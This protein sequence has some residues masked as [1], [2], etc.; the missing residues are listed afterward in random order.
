MN[1]AGPVFN[2]SRSPTRDREKRRYCPRRDL[3]C[4]IVAGLL[5]IALEIPEEF[6]RKDVEAVARSLIGKVKAGCGVERIEQEMLRLQRFQLCRI[7]EAD[8]HRAVVQ[9][10]VAAIRLG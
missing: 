5:W 2:L 9:R 1:I 3:L 8:R 7:G 4:E 6:S 10:L